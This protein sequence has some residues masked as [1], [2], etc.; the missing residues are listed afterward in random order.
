VSSAKFEENI[1]AIYYTATDADIATGRTWYGA[2]LEIAERIANGNAVIGSG[3]IAALSP[4]MGW[5]P[6]LELAARCLRT[7][8]FTGHYGAC[9][10]KAKRI[11]KGEH[12]SNVLNGWKTRAFFQCIVTGGKCSDVCI[13]RHAIA[14]CHGREATDAERRAPRPTKR[15]HMVYEKYAESYRTVAA[16]VGLLPSELQAITWVAWRRNKGIVD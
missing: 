9:T 14:I 2:A 16:E 11:A 8:R 7:R 15:G 4:N 5:K 12:P 6:N 13:D 10:R 3:V 1:R